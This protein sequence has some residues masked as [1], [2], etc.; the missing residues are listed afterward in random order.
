MLVPRVTTLSSESPGVSTMRITVPAFE[1]QAF[2]SELDHEL[3]IRRRL[4][5]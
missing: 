5:T 2:R 1:D 3:G 4:R